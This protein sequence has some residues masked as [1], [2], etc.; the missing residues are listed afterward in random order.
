MPGFRFLTLPIFVLTALAT[1]CAPGDFAVDA[2]VDEALPTR[3]HLQ[4]TTEAPGLSW[5]EYGGE[6]LGTAS[7]PRSERA[8]T[9]H[10]HFLLGIPPHQELWYRAVTLIDGQES[11]TE[12]EIRTGGVPA[13]LPD[14]TVT[15]DEPE[16]QSDHSYLMGTMFGLTPGIF[17]IDRAG[18]W[19]WYHLIDGERMPV[20]IEREIGGDGFVFNTFSA[21]YTEDASRIQRMSFTGEDS[22]S[23]DTG[24]AHHAFTQLSDGSLAWLQLDVRSWTDHDGVTQDVVGDAVIVRDTHGEEHVVFSTWDWL[25]PVITDYW[26]E[27]FYGVGKDWT[28]ANALRWDEQRQTLLLGLRNLETVVELELDPESWEATPVL[29]LA[30]VPGSAM[31]DEGDIFR[32]GD[33]YH[34]FDYLHHP[35]FTSIGNFLALVE[36]QHETHVVEWTLDHQERKLVEVGSY[37]H[38]EQLRSLFLGMVTELHN[39]NRLVTYSSEGVVREIA[40]DG[41]VAWELQAAAGTVLGNTMMFSDYYSP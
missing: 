11:I 13:E 25:D 39:D 31:M 30:G 38:G 4:W 18:N 41:Q 15:V 20:E 28:H 29:Q 21:D 34:R 9:S 19:H 37:G 27:D 33:G 7:T 14:F 35:G 10:D 8:S 36:Y 32:Y 40:P 23:V 24:Q 1:A 17:A 3:V 6:G 12:G 26:D 16:L 2:S 22:R 5:V